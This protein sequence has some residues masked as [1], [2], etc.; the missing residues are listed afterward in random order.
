MKTSIWKWLILIVVT[1]ASLALV[2]PPKDKVQLG[3]DLQ[4][5]ISFTLEVRQD[6]SLE[7]KVTE[8]RD[9][10]IEVIR[11]RIDNMGI[12]EPSIYPDGDARIVVQ[13]PGMKAEDRERASRLIREPAHLTFQVVAAKNDEWVKA[14]FDR[15][16]VP[17][18]YEIA[19]L[20]ID[21]AE[22][23]MTQELSD[24]TKQEQLISKWVEENQL[25]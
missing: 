17:A 11:N 2:Y 14:L 19:N 3:L 1:A 25:N 7:G 12:A 16:Q 21:I 24:K 20:S 10:A 18:N 4:G 6:D 9:Q 13:I 15:A 22:K 23:V 8:A 5:G